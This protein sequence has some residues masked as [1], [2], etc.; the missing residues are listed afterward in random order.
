[1]NEKCWRSDRGCEGIPVEIRW[2]YRNDKPRPVCQECLDK[3]EFWGDVIREVHGLDPVSRKSG[4]DMINLVAEM[5]EKYHPMNG[6]AH[7]NENI[8]FIK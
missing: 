3:E 8:K 2:D 7:A 6:D 4:K 5:A 1:M